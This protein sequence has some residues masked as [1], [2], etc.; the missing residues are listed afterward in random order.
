MLR[1]EQIS[2]HQF[3]GGASA[4]NKAAANLMNKEVLSHCISTARTA[5]GAG[6]YE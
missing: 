6:K 3:V 4:P 1:P 2:N 5:S